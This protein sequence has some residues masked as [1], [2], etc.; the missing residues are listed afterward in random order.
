MRQKNKKQLISKMGY[1][2]K[3]NITSTIIRKEL[4][5]KKNT[6]HINSKTY[7]LF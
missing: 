1:I 7:I 6:M 2:K 3:K 5:W 4:A